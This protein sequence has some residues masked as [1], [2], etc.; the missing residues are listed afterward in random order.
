[1]I[2][3]MIFRQKAVVKTEPVSHVKVEPNSNT[4]EEQEGQQQ[5]VKPVIGENSNV[6]VM[7][8]QKQQPST[9]T[10]TPS[11]SPSSPPS[12]PAF[13]PQQPDDFE[14]D[15][16][17]GPSGLQQEP[18]GNTGN[19]VMVGQQQMR[20]YNDSSDDDDDSGNER[21]MAMWRPP[22]A[23]RYSQT[24]DN[25]RYVIGQC[26]WRYDQADQAP[27]NESDNFN[28]LDAPQSAS[29][30]NNIPADEVIDLSENDSNETVQNASTNVQSNC[31]HEV[32][33]A[34]DLQLDWLSDSSSDNEIVCMIHD[35][36]VKHSHSNESV[37]NGTNGEVPAIDLT[38]SDDE[39][40]SFRRENNSNRP[41]Q[42]NMMRDNSF[43]HY[44]S[45]MRS[46]SYHEDNRNDR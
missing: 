46:S 35:H 31:S 27:N 24:E 23:F 26:R 10:P 1:M 5:D 3:C 4:N 45:A 43:L 18:I 36:N 12:P 32:L 41:W 8:Q 37:V 17:A 33:T 7:Q 15:P 29:N 44:R 16:E 30:T 14:N 39:E 38:V 34:P 20:R 2:S 9:P 21:K 42:R 40:T 11:P 22:A 6:I 28:D 19:C 13:Q 25:P